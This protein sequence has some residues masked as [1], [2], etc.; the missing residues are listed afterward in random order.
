MG[1][2]PAVSLLLLLIPML[3]VEGHWTHFRRAPISMSPGSC[4]SAN[5]ARHSGYPFS[6]AIVCYVTLTFASLSYIAIFAKISL[7]RLNA[8]SVAA[9][10]VMAFL[11][12]SACA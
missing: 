8:L 9:A 3:Y 5:R 4:R 1:L 6:P 12:T 10:G 11:I 7:Q 2:S